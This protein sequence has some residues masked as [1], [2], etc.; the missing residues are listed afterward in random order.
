MI[1]QLVA[2]AIIAATVGLVV[3]A[4]LTFLPRWVRMPV[5]GGVAGWIIA[6]L[7]VDASPVA[8]ALAI[9]VGALP[10]MLPREAFVPRLDSFGHAI[11]SAH[12]GYG[13]WGGWYGNGG[14]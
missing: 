3:G 10:A 8:V 9:V 12:G 7:V 4:C 1:L 14:N 5:A 6:T 2:S 11:G 13:W